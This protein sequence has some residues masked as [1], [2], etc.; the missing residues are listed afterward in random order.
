LRIGVPTEWFWDVVDPEVKAAADDVIATLVAAGATAHEV[1]LPHAH[2]SETIGWTVMLAEFASLHEITWDRLAEYDTG[3][4]DAL[5][6]AQFVT[7]SDY[8]RAQRLRYLLQR[9]FEA[10]FD[11]VDVLIVPGSIGVAP[12]LDEMGM[13][14][15]GTFYSYIEYFLRTMF[16]FNVTGLPALSVPSGL[17]SQ[18]LPM[19]VQ[20]VARPFGEATAFRAAYAFQSAT[21]HHRAVPPLLAASDPNDLPQ[22]RRQPE[23]ARSIESSTAIP[24]TAPPDP[25]VLATLSSMADRRGLVIGEAA[26]DSA[27][28][29]DTWLAPFQRELREHPLSYLDLVEPS[30]VFQWIERGGRSVA[31]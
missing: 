5:P 8:L 30:V 24:T 11:D 14:I 19:G 13:T 1:S 7:S 17:S 3:N 18:G 29:L 20:I 9:D 25:A 22:A 10:A 26:L 31:P 21:D 6:A 27:A 2:L 4:I 16:I 23:P 28:R 12:R 15:D